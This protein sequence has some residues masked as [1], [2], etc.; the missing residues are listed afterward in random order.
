MKNNICRLC[1]KLNSLVVILELKGMPIAAQHFLNKNEINVKD[2]FL[3]LEILQCKNCG[4]VQL[5]IDPVSYYKNV[6]TAASISGDARKARL[7]QMTKLSDKY[8]LKGKKVI[9][10]GCGTG[11]MLDIMHEAGM[12]AYGLEFSE[13]SVLEGKKKNRKIIKGYLDELNTIEDNPF[14]G[15]VCFNFLEHMPNINSFVKKM[16]DNLSDRAIG[17][18]TV[19]NLEYLLRTKSFYEFVAD[20]LSY[21]TVDT[22]TRLFEKNNFKI[23]EHSLINNENDILLIVKK[24]IASKIEHKNK[25]ISILDF[26]N[27]YV[28]VENL[29]NELKN[30]SSSYKKNKKKIAVW[31]AGHRTLALLAI[32]TF[33]DIEY[34]ID[35]APFKQGKFSPIN[36]TEIVNPETLFKK[37]IDLLIVMLPGIYPDEVISK[38]KKYKPKFEIAKL[39]DNKIEFI[40][41]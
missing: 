5:D 41:L 25:N 19:P 2:K 3:D 1:E 9:E 4:L 26:K 6:I 14:D 27:D 40:N 35:S 18:I 22:I 12:N 13:T 39:V 8:L 30:I 28:E 32:S 20:H 10:I 17:L 21:F 34:I 23:L 31:G 24:D 16:S 38:I 37:P 33:K 36:Y 7:E 11:A 29:I 15:F